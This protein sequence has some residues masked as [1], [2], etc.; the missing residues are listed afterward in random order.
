MRA[1]L[2]R[3]QAFHS[4]GNVHPLEICRGYFCSLFSFA[5]LQ[6]SINFGITGSSQSCFLQSWTGYRA[7]V[8][9]RST[10]IYKDEKSCQSK[11]HA[12]PFNDIK[13]ILR[14]PKERDSRFLDRLQAPLRYSWF[15]QFEMA[16]SSSSSETVIT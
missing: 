7:C 9:A 1:F 5:W 6:L 10:V 11:S 16:L 12:V 15:K 8:T 3:V 13:S 4:G 14:L 2:R